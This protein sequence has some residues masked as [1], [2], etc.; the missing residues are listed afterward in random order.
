[1]GGENKLSFTR[2]NKHGRV[3]AI[4]ATFDFCNCRKRLF[5]MIAVRARAF[6]EIF[7]LCFGE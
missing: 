4:F 2:N 1:M 7:A 5:A 6:F 3:G